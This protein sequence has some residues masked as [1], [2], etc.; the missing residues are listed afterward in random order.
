MR[1]RSSG[2]FITVRKPVCGCASQRT[3]RQR[4]PA[5]AGRLLLAIRVPAQG[6]E[7]GAG[8][9]TSNMCAFY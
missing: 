6:F 3:G 1:L 5:Q 4:A 2:I 9:V 7:S 8:F